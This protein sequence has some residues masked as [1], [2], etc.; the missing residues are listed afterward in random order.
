MSKLLRRASQTDV[1]R[2]EHSDDPE[3]WITFRAEFSKGDMNQLALV[4]PSNQEDRQGQLNFLEGWFKL[5]VMDWSLEDD[6]GNRLKP[7]VTEYRELSLE[8][9]KWVDEEL[10]KH[11]ETL[12]GKEQ[13][14]EEKKLSE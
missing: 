10:G 5:A 4:A 11:I 9:G 12:V 3:T 14:E 8:A 6:D 13:A 2:V 1:R 7:S